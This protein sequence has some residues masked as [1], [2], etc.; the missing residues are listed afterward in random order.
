MERVKWV[1]LWDPVSRVIFTEY[2]F[3]SAGFA[4]KNKKIRGNIK[5]KSV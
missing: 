1:N 5:K 4:K 2:F 3:C